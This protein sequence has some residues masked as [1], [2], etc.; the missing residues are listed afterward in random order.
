MACTEYDFKLKELEEDCLEELCHIL[1]VVKADDGDPLDASS[2]L[3]KQ[4]SE[5]LP[6]S[7]ESLASLEGMTPTIM[8]HEEIIL[9]ITEEYHQMRRK[10]LLKKRIMNNKERMNLHT[11]FMSEE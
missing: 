2:S 9:T 10:L 6:R 11:S 1:S 4:I 7:T 5:E 3:L 8:Q